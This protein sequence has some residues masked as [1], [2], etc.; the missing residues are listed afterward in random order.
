[1]QQQ[2]YL[3]SFGPSKYHLLPVIKLNNFFTSPKKNI[4]MPLTTC[5]I[6]TITNTCMHTTIKIRNTAKRTA[7]KFSKDTCAINPPKIWPTSSK[8]FMMKV[9]YKYA[10]RLIASPRILNN[11]SIMLPPFH[12]WYLL[13]TIYTSKCKYIIAQS[14]K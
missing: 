14:F 1:M 6:K 7:I 2:P 3:T 12:W 13:R 8:Q 10:V 9:T 11:K 4:T 5:Q